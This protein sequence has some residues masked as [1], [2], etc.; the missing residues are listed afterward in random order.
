MNLI[1]ASMTALPGV[2]ETLL[3]LGAGEMGFGGTPFGKGEATLEAYLQSCV[4]G[5]DPAKL[6]P[7]IVPQTV[8]WVVDESGTAVGMVRVRHC[9]NE[10]LLKSGGHIGCYIRPAWRGKGCG[11]QALRLALAELRKLGESRAL[12][13]VREDNAPS[14]G[15]IESCGGKLEN[16]LP[17]E[18]TGKGTRRYWIDLK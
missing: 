11:R 15:M 2:R 3:E 7:G 12:L 9:L 16:T 8:Y 18:K 17:D 6:K 14:I 5:P 10:W 13:T 1:P 4:D